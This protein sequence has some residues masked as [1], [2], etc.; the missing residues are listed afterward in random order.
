[1]HE[2]LCSSH[3]LEQSGDFYT[4]CC[5]TVNLV[6]L[7]KGEI[8]TLSHILYRVCQQVEIH[9]LHVNCFIH[10]CV[11]IAVEVNQQRKKII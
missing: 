7:H 8:L 3:I 4:K 6:E 2:T 5:N 9:V 11:S 10:H 1:M